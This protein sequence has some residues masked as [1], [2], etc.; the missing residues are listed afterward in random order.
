MPVHPVD[1]LER[2]L[3][4]TVQ[5]SEY[6]QDSHTLKEVACILGSRLFEAVSPASHTGSQSE[7]PPGGGPLPRQVQARGTLW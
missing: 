4:D 3:F 1:T 5:S 2:Q 7:D 6:F